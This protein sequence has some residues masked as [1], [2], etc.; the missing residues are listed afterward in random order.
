[1]TRFAIATGTPEA[2]EAAVAIV[3]RGGTAIDGLVAAAFTL[4]VTEP[5]FCG[6]GGGGFI[7]LRSPDGKVEAIDGYGAMPG[8]PSQQ[9]PPRAGGLAVPLPYG[10]GIKTGIGHAACAVPGVLRALAKAWDLGG[11]LPWAELLQP[12]IHHASVGHRL[13]RNVAYFLALSAASIQGFSPASRQ[14][15][16]QD[17][18]ITPRAAGEL[19]VQADLA[20]SLQVVATEGAEALYTGSLSTKLVSDMA[21]HEGVITAEDLRAYQAVVRQPLQISWGDWQIFTNPAPS[22]GGERLAFLLANSQGLGLP[23]QA[24]LLRRAIEQGRGLFQSGTTHTSAVDQQGYAASLTMSNGYGSGVVVPGTGIAL[25][26]SLGELELHPEGLHYPPG[27]RLES[28]MSPTIAV[29]ADG[30]V[31]ALGSPGAER[32]PTAIWLTWLNLSSGAE[33][34]ADLIQAVASPRWHVEARPEGWTFLYEPGVA[35]QTLAAEFRLRPFETL[36]MYFGSAQVALLNRAGTVQ[37]VADPRRTGSV[38][39]L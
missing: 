3:E 22:R 31:I 14:V 20:Q 27:E 18:G 17:D 9:P 38:G 33:S 12:A 25:N 4:L 8:L 19:F 32:I 2:A 30:R 24:K 5:L 1:M 34:E 28:N 11:C 13:H 29:H 16:F 26:N 21:A 37:A 39:C 36:D 7:L 6:L 23:E 35:A 10:D 15:F